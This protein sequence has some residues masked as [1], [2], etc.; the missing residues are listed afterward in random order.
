MVEL[1]RAGRTPGE[2]RATP[3]PCPL[4]RTGVWCDTPSRCPPPPSM[5]PPHRRGR[6]RPRAESTR[7]LPRWTPR[8]IVC[9]STSPSVCWRQSFRNHAPCRSPRRNRPLHRTT[10]TILGVHPCPHEGPWATARPGRPAALLCRHRAERSPD[11]PHDPR[12]G[13]TRAPSPNPRTGSMS[14]G[15]R[16]TRI[17]SRPAMIA[18]LQSIKTSVQR[19]WFPGHHGEET[20]GAKHGAV[21]HRRGARWLRNR[22][23]DGG[24]STM[25][26]R[27][28]RPASRAAGPTSAERTGAFTRRRAR[29]SASHPSHPP[30]RE[31][32]RR[33]DSN[34]PRPRRERSDAIGALL[35]GLGDGRGG[36]PG[37][38]HLDRARH[39]AADP[40]NGRRGNGTVPPARSRSPRRTGR[41][42]ALWGIPRSGVP[43]PGRRRRRRRQRVL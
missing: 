20:G 41:Q 32:Q 23:V 27:M 9:S 19:Y 4:R 22:G 29:E 37:H 8:C 34:R 6:A 12:P 5:R 21:V 31:R 35:R 33:S 30:C 10:G 25:E 3:P 11:D 14:R 28:R 43:A 18:T 1:V 38:R 40:V 26:S 7:V 24:F 42:A 16:R 17:P 2:L 39:G 36:R 15:V 13:A